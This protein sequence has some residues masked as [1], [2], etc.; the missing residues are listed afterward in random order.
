[1]FD[2][3]KKQL[4]ANLDNQFEFYQEFTSS[5]YWNVNQTYTTSTYTNLVITY[6]MTTVSNPSFYVNGA[7]VAS[8]RNT[9]P[10]GATVSDA[11]DRLYIGNR[12][13]RDKT[14]DG[15]INE[16]VLFPKILTTAEIISMKI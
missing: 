9:T 1:V 6:T 15:Y 16:L 7:L 10:S 3:G 5:G 12:S 11:T 14:F 2:K 13:A 8:T 4:F